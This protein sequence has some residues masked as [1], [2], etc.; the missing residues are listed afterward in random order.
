MITIQQYYRGRDR[1]Y[2]NELT[3]EKQLNAGITVQRINELISILDAA[4]VEIQINP[5]TGSPVSSGWRP[6]AINGATPGAAAKSKHMRCEACD[7]YDPDGEIDDWA[8]DHPE[9]LADIGLWQEH[10][11]STK[12]WAHF[13]IVPPRSGKRVF[14]P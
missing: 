11:S 10:P 7:L 6:T 3:Q 9:V 1:V 5:E 4:G 8:F 2:G 14:Y 12:N 13:Q